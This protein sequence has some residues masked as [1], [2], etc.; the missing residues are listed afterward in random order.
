MPGPESQ[1]MCRNSSRVFSREQDRRRPQGSPPKQPK[2][3]NI[4]L[5]K[6]PI[7]LKPPPKWLNNELIPA[8]APHQRHNWRL[9]DLPAPRVHLPKATLG[10]IPPA[11]LPIKN[12]RHGCR[13]G[14]QQ[15]CTR[16]KPY[17]ASSELWLATCF[18]VPF[19]RT[20]VSVDRIVRARR[21]PWYS[22][23]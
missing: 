6:P 8:R 23:S 7:P 3:L 17:F 15:I 21:S 20:N 4:D 14:A 19:C 9:A 18:Q 5:K 13:R 2:L 16:I 22:E 1:P 10:L 12:P 11:F